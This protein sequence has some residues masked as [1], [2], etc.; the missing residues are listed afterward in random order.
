MG[1]PEHENSRIVKEVWN[2]GHIL[3]FAVFAIEADRYLTKRRLSRLTINTATMLIIL[4]LATSIEACQSLISGRIASLQ[5]IFLGLA[6]GLL[7]LCWNEAYRQTLG[8]IIILRTIGI[9]GIAMCMIPL[10]FVVIDEYRE[11]WDFPVLSNFESFLDVSRWEA[12]SSI[13]RVTEP[14]KTGR[15]ALKI[16]L[17]TD[18]YSGIALRHFPENWSNARALTFSV[19]N[20]GDLVTMHYRIHDEK[21]RLGNQEYSDRFNGH[22]DLVFGWNTITIEMEEIENGPKNRKIDIDHIREFV[23]FVV[24]QPEARVFYIDDVKLLLNETSDNQ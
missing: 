23:L 1:G 10:V 17:D 15:Y 4:G 24:E 6:G 20:P 7:I 11:W 19:Y 18:K 22:T 14:V 5:D 13:E 9:S 21:H 8:R 3:F 2:L 16:P 12:K